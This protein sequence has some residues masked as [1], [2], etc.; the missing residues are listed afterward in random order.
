ML[1]LSR[2]VDEAILIGDDVKVTVVDIRGEKVRLGIDAPKAIPV[3][4]EEVYRRIHETVIDPSE[5]DP[6]MPSQA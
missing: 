2:H 5:T 4:R 6:L 3:H 1:I